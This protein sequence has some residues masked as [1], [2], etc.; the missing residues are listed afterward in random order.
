MSVDDVYKDLIS[1]ALEAAS[2]VAT[3]D[4]INTIYG[5]IKYNFTDSWG[6]I[7]NPA[8]NPVEYEN[9]KLKQEIKKIRDITPCPSC[10]GGIMKVKQH[11]NGRNQNVCNKCNL[12]VWI[13]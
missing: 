5:H 12:S 1:E 8:A 4:Q 11:P 7:S 13:G 2:V 10:A 3:P 9:S 6:Y